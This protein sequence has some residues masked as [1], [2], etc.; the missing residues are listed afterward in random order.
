MPETTTPETV[1]RLRHHRTSP[2][3]VRQV[4]RLIVGSGL[5]I[6]FA[7]TAIGAVGAFFLTRLLA[8]S[9]P[10]FGRGDPL[11]VAAAGVFLLLAAVVACLLPARRAAGINPVEAL[12]AE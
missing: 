4:L 3:K 11:H 2:T 10:A 1:A 9:F 7:G 8:K 5:R 12:R 6:A